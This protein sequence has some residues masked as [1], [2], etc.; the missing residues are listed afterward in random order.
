MARR[1]AL[2]IGNTKYDDSSLVQLVAPQA[3]ITALTAVLK[4]PSR[5]D[6]SEVSPL[7]NESVES[8]RR[9]I[10]K[11]V[12]HRDHD[13]LLLFYFSGHGLKDEEGLLYLAVRDTE[14]D[15]LSATAIP[16]AF[17]DSEM[18]RSTSR[19]QLI[20]LDCCN[21]GAIG[22]GIKGPENITVG[23]KE[24]FDAEGYGRV[25]VT[26][27]DATQYAW[28]GNT[29]VGQS[30]QSVFTHYLIEGLQTGNADKE[31]DGRITVDELFDYVSKN[32]KNQTSKQTPCKFVYDQKGENMLIA[33]NPLAPTSSKSGISVTK[34]RAASLPLPP[35]Q[36]E[37][38][39]GEIADAAIEGKVIPIL[40]GDFPLCCR[41]TNVPWTKGRR[42]FTP[43]QSELSVILADRSEYPHDNK[44][45]LASVSQHIV[46]F[47]GNSALRSELKKIL[48][49]DWIPSRP[50]AT[51][52]ALASAASK[53]NSRFI[54]ITTNYDD[55]LE[56]S[57]RAA[58][59]PFLLLTH[60]PENRGTIWMAKPV[61]SERW[62]KIDDPR[63]WMPREEGA[64]IVKLYGGVDRT[65]D[66]QVAFLLP[67]IDLVEP[68]DLPSWV[69][70]ELSIQQKLFLGANP[71]SLYD[72]SFLHYLEKR[73]DYSLHK[74]WAIAWDA[75]AVEKRF[76]HSRY[77]EFIPVGLS[78]FLETL[79]ETITK[80]RHLPRGS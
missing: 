52:V 13:D 12:K 2:I 53:C 16:A 5:G 1:V 47:L 11:F 27:T 64:V 22:R 9:G 61:E 42:D 36:L 65:H 55:A 67:P 48:H 32:V 6:F 63:F 7:V 38:R 77:V 34:A 40:G 57:F 35:E 10:S 80:Q 44:Q 68:R 24:A 71:N 31:P 60:T 66:S 37:I 58:K 14:H 79:A 46:D 28:E 78:Q 43:S 30:D 20:I 29:F 76:W 25:V 73:F 18:K 54:I 4:D 56:F 15:M 62:V 33:R 74:D 39:Y 23:T 50:H 75:A 72:R 59:E 19:R 69:R 8:L 21:S 26:A 17:V 3:D 51:L 49:L 45:D 70:G 41:P